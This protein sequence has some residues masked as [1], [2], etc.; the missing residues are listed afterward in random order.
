MTFTEFSIVYLSIGTPFGVYYFFNNR[1]GNPNFAFWLKTAGVVFFWCAYAALLS[2]R[3][4]QKITNTGAF[5]DSITENEIE[6]AARSLLASYSEIPPNDKI[7]SFFEFRETVE[8]YIGLT[9]TLQ[10]STGEADYKNELFT[11]DGRKNQD[12]LLANRCL[13]RKNLRRLKAHQIQA[14][15]DF[16]HIFENLNYQEFHGNNL[17]KL[18]SA[19]ILLTDSLD[20]SAGA[21][22]L[23]QIKREIERQNSG[24]GASAKKEVW[25]SLRPEQIGL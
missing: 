3:H 8:R 11:I 18:L 16:L 4:S 20:D 9:S 15:S 19:A 5:S 24:V 6:K 21:A 14:Q 7:F 13:Q 10:P 22:A 1:S 2:L 12:L 17:E 23:N 25:N